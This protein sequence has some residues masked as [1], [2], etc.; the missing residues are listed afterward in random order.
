[1]YV[2]LKKSACLMVC[3]A[4]SVLLFSFSPA[5]A[6]TQWQKLDTAQYIE[7][8]IQCQMVIEDFLWFHQ[9][10]PENNTQPKPLRSDII[11][12]QKIEAKVLNN[13]AQETALLQLHGIDL[14]ETALH[15]ELNRIIETSQLP[16]RL[17]ELFKQFDNDVQTISECFIRP[18]LVH[19]WLRQRHDIKQ[20][21]SQWW[22]S[23]QQIWHD[24]F[25]YQPIKTKH[26]QR[27]NIPASN[28]TNSFNRL[29]PIGRT[30]HVAVWT[31]NEMI[32]WGGLD[33][34]FSVV[35]TGG[36]YNPMTN[37]W[38]DTD[39]IQSPPPRR[40]PMAVWTGTEMIVWGGFNTSIFENTGGRY[41]PNTDVWTATSLVN[42]PDGVVGH[43]MIW[44]GDEMI[45]WGGLNP[46]NSNE[47]GRYDPST[48]TWS[49]T[50]LFNA[51]TVRNSHTA[52]WTGSN[53][54]VWGGSGSTPFLNDGGS[55]N[56]S[57]DSWTAISAVAAPTGRSFHSAVWTGRKM[58]IWG[59]API[60][61]ALTGGLYNPQNDS[62]ETISNTNEPSARVNF[63]SVWTGTEFIVWGG[64]NGLT[65]NTGGKYNLM[66]D[67][68]TPTN[69]NDAPPPRNDAIAVWTGAEM[70][71]W[72]GFDVN[73]R[74]NTGARYEPLSDTWIVDLI[75]KDGFDQ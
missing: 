7:K 40:E 45:I 61:T 65:L 49:A 4:F 12:N 62:W 10:W 60:P 52:V 73:A 57:T 55:Y 37:T 36:R 22:Q 23:N 33:D 26:N 15:K 5:N 17:T 56:P 54:I 64:F 6:V 32:V 66:S 46:N 30:E 58:L 44:T 27:I 72:G 29:A 70:I 59:G 25:S 8:R 1:M 19:Q 34:T 47:G 20:P 35:N 43:S 42:A 53:M 71:V 50:S 38:Q 13:L 69:V 11:S 16:A 2:S 68:W 28:S 3:I 31:G 21:F 39:T 51:P 14:D 67:S 41:N 63:T 75:F 48:D 24:K 74:T 9:L 18:K